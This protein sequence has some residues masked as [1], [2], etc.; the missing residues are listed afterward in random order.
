[1]QFINTILLAAAA[2][3]SM[4]S[5]T[6]F[7]QFINQ[8]AVN[9]KNIIFTAN[10]GLPAIEPLVLGPAAT[11]TQNFPSGWIGNFYSYN[12][13]TRNVPGMLGEVCFDGYAGA[14]YYD[15]SSIVNAF[16]NEGIKILY[17]FEA[18]ATMKL[19]DLATSTVVSGCQTSDCQNQYNASGDVKTLSTAGSGLVCLV[20]NLA[21]V[22]RRR[23]GE[24]FSRDFVM[25]KDPSF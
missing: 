14:T 22:G 21:T 12:E 16:D 15:I 4:A 23:T 24:L 3:A 2:L 1:M 25:S 17:P 5:A 8:D 19:K 11:A 13:G 20:G 6:N 7:V 9:T 18:H 10:A